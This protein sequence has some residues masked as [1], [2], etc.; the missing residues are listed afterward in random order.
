M[1]APG[2]VA[3]GVLRR[4]HRPAARRRVGAGHRCRLGRTGDAGLPGHAQ[5][6]RRPPE[7]PGPTGHPSVPGF[8]VGRAGHPAAM[9]I[10]TSLLLTA[11]G[12]ILYFAVTA[13]VS[14]ISIQTVG[15]ILL[16]VGVI[17][18]LVSLL[19]SFLWA[20]RRRDEAVVVRDPH[21]G[22]RV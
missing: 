15:L 14:G 2:T 21:Y 10:G 7:T 20:D 19:W 8:P 11:I 1:R 5:P 4:R 17:G 9:G 18:L 3:V 6:S 13:T 22:P 16:I 12:A